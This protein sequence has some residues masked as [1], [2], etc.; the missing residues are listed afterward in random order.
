MPTLKDVAKHAGVS[1]GTA[2]AVVN[3]KPWV[4]ESVRRRV[5]KAIEE[6]NY[7]PSQLGRNLRTRQT[8]TIGVIVP[9]ITNPF[10]PQVIRSVQ[11]VAR[12]AGYVIVLM[13]SNESYE[14][15]RKLFEAVLSNEVDGIILI[16]DILPG[17]DLR[18]HLE[19][20]A[21][22]VVAVENDFGIPELPLVQV[23]AVHGGYLA[24]RHLIDLGHEHVAIIT[25]PLED[26][27]TYASLGRFEGYK[28][29]LKQR[30][31]VF[32]PQLVEQADFTYQGGYKASRALLE[33]RPD[34]TAIFAS[35]DLMAIGA[36][37]AGKEMGR[38]IPED[39]AVVGYDD[40][41]EAAYTSPPLT[42][43]RLPKEEL[44]RTAA[45]VLIQK[46]R[47]ERTDQPLTVIYETELIVRQSCGANR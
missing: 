38:R 46:L 20:G 37:E 2:S 40:I 7:R 41:P 35:N 14:I 34:V 9:D 19:A 27:R 3:N 5:L 22:P 17:E 26:D 36:M 25:G 29:A 23:D 43:V 31:L 1:L 47:G 15:G 4:R 13:D 33:R 10:F 44:G 21:P 24:T 6:L 12:Q 42:T 45:E 28:T 39:L 18:K 11:A 16:G 30:G 32:D 8:R